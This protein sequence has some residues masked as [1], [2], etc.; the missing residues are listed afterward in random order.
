[1]KRF[2]TITIISLVAIFILYSCGNA[3]KNAKPGGPATDTS[4]VNVN[5]PAFNEDSA[6]YFTKKQCD[7]GPRVNNTQ[8]HDKCAVWLIQK[9]KSLSA[10][11]MVQ[12]GQVTA[13]NGT[14]LKIQN[15]ITSFNPDK[16]FRI[17]LCS[18]WDSRPFAD[19]DEDA[20][21]HR[22]PIDGANDGASGVGVLTEIAR[23]LNQHKTDV[24]ID[25]AF[26][27]AED[28]GEPKGDTEHQSDDNWA[29]GTQYWCKNPHIPNYHA[30]YGILLDMVGVPNAKVTKE[31]TSMQYAA[32][33]VGKVWGKAASI[34]YGNYFVNQQTQAI[35][36]DHFSINHLTSIPTIDIIHH[37][38]TTPSGFYKYW[39]T[40]QDNM[41]NVDKKTLKAVGQTLLTVI[42]E[43]PN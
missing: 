31:G 11:V 24:G 18:H 15:I 13:F 40:L 4:T 23:I 30:N 25:I 37:D 42:F 20:S 34:N 41:Q 38:D 17:L 39:H 26:F 10:N 19:E 8:A 29:L 43:A 12:K 9:M 35:N 16:T 14:S 5:I 36:D 33:V 22:T 27:D 3:N 6:F 1:M 2:N 32:D 28:Y 21:K 7:F